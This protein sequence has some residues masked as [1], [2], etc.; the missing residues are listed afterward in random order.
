MSPTTADSNDSTPARN[1]IVNADGNN[2]RTRASVISGSCG[3]GKLP[4][5][6]PN[7]V[8]IVVTGSANPHTDIA[9]TPI[10]IRNIGQCGRQS[11]QP[12]IEA[13]E[14]MATAKVAG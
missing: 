12:T 10:A 13:S 14:A 2:S 8:P 11:L 4:G 3:I 1:A 9:P 7:R 5:S 6:S